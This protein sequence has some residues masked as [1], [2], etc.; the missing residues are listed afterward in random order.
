M[1]K[2]PNYKKSYST[3]SLVVVLVMAASILAAAAQSPMS[4]PVAA[5]VVSPM[6]EPAPAPGPDCMAYLLN[7][8]DCLSYVQ[9][10]SNLT[11]PEKPCCPE[12]K[13]LVNDQPICLCELLA[14][15][16]QSPIPIDVPRAFG[17]PSVCKIDL[18]FT[19]ASGCSLL[20]VP[21]A[22]PALSPA[23]DSAPEPSSGN[24]LTIYFPQIFLSRL[25]ILLIFLLLKLINIMIYPFFSPY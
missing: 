7:L 2:N 16:D 5:P 15:P 24:H 4:A 19:P 6:A 8:S 11:K 20:G 17:L 25:F 10:G 18:P 13:N 23:G 3:S 21:I 12:V 14:H 22:A 9:Q 1:A